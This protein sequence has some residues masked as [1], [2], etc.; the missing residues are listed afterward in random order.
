MIA[1]VS[2]TA[3]SLFTLFILGAFRQQSLGQPLAWAGVSGMKGMK[4]VKPGLG[5]HLIGRS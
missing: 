1:D 5:E 4:L 3:S 2:R